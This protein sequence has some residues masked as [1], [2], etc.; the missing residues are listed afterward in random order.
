MT[1]LTDLGVTKKIYF[2]NT[3]FSS[4][5]VITIIIIRSVNINIH[6]VLFIFKYSPT[7][8]FTPNPCWFIKTAEV[9]EQS[10]EQQSFVAS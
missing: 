5:A 2:R 1:T 4:L 10:Q 9:G 8:G 7:K 6:L 3:L